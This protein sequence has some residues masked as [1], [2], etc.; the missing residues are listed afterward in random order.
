MQ[1]ADKGVPAEVMGFEYL[2]ADSLITCKMGNSE[3]ILR[4]NGKVRLVA[5]DRVHVIWPAAE[6]HFF[7][8]ETGRRW[9]P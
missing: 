7:E 9:E 1:L 6:T 5:G 3:C 8:T 2:G 4:Q